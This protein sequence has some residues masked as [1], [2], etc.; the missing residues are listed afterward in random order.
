MN[1]DLGLTVTAT[2]VFA[3]AEPAEQLLLLPDFHSSAI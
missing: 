3:K 2:T 1:G